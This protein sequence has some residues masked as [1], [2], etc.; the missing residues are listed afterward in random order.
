[1]ADNITD[2]ERYFSSQELQEQP[3]VQQ[4][5]F[6]IKLKLSM[7]DEPEFIP[8][9]E[10]TE[11]IPE[12]FEAN[13]YITSFIEQA[14]YRTELFPVYQI[15]LALPSW[16]NERI[17]TSY[18]KAGEKR[19]RIYTEVL[20]RRKLDENRVTDVATQD[21]ET[22]L[23]ENESVWPTFEL[24]PIDLDTSLLDTS[25]QDDDENA[26]YALTL[27]C[28]AIQDTRA[29]KKCRSRTFV[30]TDINHVILAIVSDIYDDD[31]KF[32]FFSPPEN[33]NKYEQ[34]TIPAMSIYEAV[35]FLQDA[36]GIYEAGIMMYT[37]RRGTYIL[38]KLGPGAHQ[39]DL[40]NDYKEIEFDVRDPKLNTKIGS[41]IEEG[42]L[43]FTPPLSA[44]EFKPRDE[45]LRELSG[46]TLKLLGNTRTAHDVKLTTP[47]T[48]KSS[49][50]DL[51]EELEKQNHPQ[52][53]RERVF[54]DRYTNSFSLSEFQSNSALNMLTFRATIPFADAEQLRVNYL[55]NIRFADPDMN[56]RYRGRYIVRTRT[57]AFKTQSEP[58]TF[59][60]I[61][62]IEASRVS[63]IV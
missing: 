28:F 40:D 46:E 55:I 9:F 42:K 30:N 19:L 38:P 53:K 24:I 10:D 27:N 47:L 36:Y 13:I 58:K 33:K 51:D 61:G 2:E 23:E 14:N 48:L 43:I 50:Q 1:M 11:G 45:S 63:D 39:P 60:M 62:S 44:L 35:H 49:N 18:A 12:P 56:A 4:Y 22:E 6:E 25:L 26:E 59:E 57:L 54:H 37:D 17:K 16:L 8:G 32:L 29:N 21:D 34:I 15:R 5:F 7:P 3:A 20:R 31:R 41:I 52:L